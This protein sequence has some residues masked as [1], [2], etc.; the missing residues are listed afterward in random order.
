MEGFLYT[1]ARQQ[2]CLVPNCLYQLICFENCLWKTMSYHRS[3]SLFLLF[4]IYLTSYDLL[5]TSSLVS[6]NKGKSLYPLGNT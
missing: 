5:L 4:S 3:D 2:K 1:V 6:M